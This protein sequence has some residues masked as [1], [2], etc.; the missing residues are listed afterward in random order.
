MTAIVTHPLW[1]ADQVRNDVDVAAFHHVIASSYSDG[2]LLSVA[3]WICRIGT[4]RCIVLWIPA[5]AGMTVKGAGN[6]CE[7]RWE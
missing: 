7:G 6:D 4:V 5:Y 2:E 3:S 1:I